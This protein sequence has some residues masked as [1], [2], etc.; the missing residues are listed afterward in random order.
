MQ[1]SALTCP[2]P[3]ALVTEFYGGEGPSLK[4]F[5][6]LVCFVFL[7]S[8]QT[9][10]NCFHATML[11]VLEHSREE[12]PPGVR[13]QLRSSVSISNTSN[14]VTARIWA[15]FST[16]DS[17]MQSWWLRDKPNP[18]TLRL[19]HETH[20]VCKLL[21]K[22]SSDLLTFALQTTAWLQTSLVSA[23]NS[24]LVQITHLRSSYSQGC[25]TDLVVPFL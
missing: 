23:C 14:K 25:P 13:T 3:A 22:Q 16:P 6:S 20:F 8:K 11:K 9:F 10:A 24:P 4:Y 19:T 1:D 15:G 18:T 21:R 2:N 17:R 12:E 5:Y 7:G